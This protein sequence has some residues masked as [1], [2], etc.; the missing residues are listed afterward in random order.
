MSQKQLVPLDEPFRISTILVGRAVADRFA[1]FGAAMAVGKTERAIAAVNAERLGSLANRVMGGSAEHR[2][3]KKNDHQS[4]LPSADH[5][6][7]PIRMKQ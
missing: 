6:S 4:E 3:W 7:P 2:E 5:H 1:A